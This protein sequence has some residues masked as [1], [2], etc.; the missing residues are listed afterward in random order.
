[1]VSNSLVA[2]HLDH[3]VDDGDD[4]LYSFVGFHVL[5]HRVLDDVDLVGLAAAADLCWIAYHSE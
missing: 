5:L 3:R 4:D 1:M 2:L